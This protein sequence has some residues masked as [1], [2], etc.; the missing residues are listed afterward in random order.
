MEIFALPLALL[1]PGGI[2]A[3]IILCGWANLDKAKAARTWRAV[4]GRIIASRV[5]VTKGTKGATF[6]NPAFIYEYQVE[7]RI[8]RGERQAF[9]SP[10]SGEIEEAEEIVART[11]PGSRTQVYYDPNYPGDAVLD[12]TPLTG[13][14]LTFFAVGAAFIFVPLGIILCAI[15]S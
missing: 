1:V 5:A 8:Y 4:E 14:Y 9:G 6:Y 11:P 15:G 10:T 3:Y 7:G 12:P 13:E 2:G